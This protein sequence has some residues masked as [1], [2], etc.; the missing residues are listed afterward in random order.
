MFTPTL[1]PDPALVRLEYC[2]T[3]AD[4]LCLH[5]TARRETVACPD[6][7]TEARRVHSRYRRHLADQLWNGQSVRLILYTRRWFCD[8]PRC[9]RRIF[10]EPLPGITSRYARR[11]AS[12]TQVFLLLAYVL[13]G[14]A[15]ARVAAG[16]G[17]PVSPDTL[18]RQLE[19]RGAYRGPGPRVLGVDDFAWLRGQRYGTLLVDLEQGMPIDLLP[20]RT[21]ASLARWLEEH[22][23]VEIISRDRGGSYAEGARKGA[24]QAVQVADRWHL[25]KNLTEPLGDLL[26]GEAELLRTTAA[27]PPFGSHPEAE[28]GP[29]TTLIS[30][31]EEIPE[32]T[33]DSP[34]AAE[35]GPR[36]HRSR[37]ERERSDR[38]RKRRLAQYQEVRE[39]APAG[40]SEREIAQRV[41][42]SRGTVH[43]VLTNDTFPERK[44]RNSA[45]GSLA[46]YADYLR[47]RWEEGCRN[48]K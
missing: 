6:C 11:T 39:L 17:M 48:A 47:R 9:T 27:L 7:G 35:P 43:K 45:L 28:S 18:L 30:T 14:E 38:A 29:D 42:I 5:L 8:E 24:P 23:G 20:D 19:R 37:R 21:T 36:D 2:A 26:A 40:L 12:Q 41:G 32:E 46:P 1:L 31:P 33:P 16:V 25:L 10:T 34:A 15:G 44:D 3:D 4:L 22:P 13:D